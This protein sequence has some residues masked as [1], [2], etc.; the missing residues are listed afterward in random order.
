MAEEN[1]ENQRDDLSAKSELDDESLLCWR[2]RNSYYYDGLDKIYRFAVRPNSRV[3]HVGCASGELLA[4]V[5]PSYGVGVD[6]DEAAI[7]LAKK[8]FSYLHFHKADLQEFEL[9][10]KFDYV[11]ICN[12]L[13][14]WQDIQKIFERILPMTTENTRIIIVYYNYLWEWILRMGSFF[15][16]RRSHS[17]QNWLPPED[18]KNLLNLSGF[19]VIRTDSSM[20]LP[21]DI[22]FLSTFFNYVLSLLPGIRYFNLVNLVVARPIPAVKSDEDLSVSVIVPCKDERQCRGGD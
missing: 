12:S 13:G 1:K 14:Q 3:L 19:E 9:E 8:R 16:M 10:E 22:P 15:K 11:L 7:E 17:Y 20:L 18:I 21:K 6:S 4:A 2:K 5:K